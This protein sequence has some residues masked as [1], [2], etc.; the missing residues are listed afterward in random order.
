[1]D[2]FEVKKFAAQNVEK[3]LLIESTCLGGEK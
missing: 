3:P 2:K 1:M